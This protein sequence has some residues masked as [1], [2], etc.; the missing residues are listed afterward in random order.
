[1]VSVPRG[2]RQAFEALVAEHEVPVAEIG[3]V[4]AQISALTVKDQFTVPLVELR[5]AWSGTLPKL[6]N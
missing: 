4:N 5:E 1:L 6:F 3:V 2:H